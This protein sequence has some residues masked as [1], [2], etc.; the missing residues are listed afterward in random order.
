[1]FEFLRN[2]IVESA[3]IFNDVSFY[4]L[5]GLLLAGLIKV[6]LPVQFLTRHLS[7]KNYKSV[8]KAALIGVPLPLCSCSVLPTAV[9]LKKQGASNGATVAFLISTPETGVDSISVTY[10]LLDPL[11]TLLRPLAAF[12]T[13][14]TAGGAVNILE[15]R[16]DEKNGSE[17]T[18][19]K[20]NIEKKSEGRNSAKSS[21]RPPVRS[22][23]TAKGFKATLQYGFGDILPEIAGWFIMGILFAGIIS[24][25]L[26]DDFFT[27]YI[28][29][30]FLSM[31]L[32]II[33][34]IPLY[35]CATGSTPIAAAL[36][37]KGLNPG[38]ALIF[39]LVGPATNIGSFFV[40]R[41]YIKKKYL[42][43][44]LV[45]LIIVSLLF[46]FIVNL[47]YDGGG[48]P[49]RASQDGGRTGL[50]SWMQIFTSLILAYLLVKIFYQA[51]IHKRFLDFC[52]RLISR[53]G[54]RPG[55][56]VKTAFLLL[57]I[58]YL[59]S[60]FYSVRIGETAIVTSFG[61]VVRVAAEPGL[62]YRYPYPFS[63]IF[64]QNHEYIRQIEIGYRSSSE[65]SILAAV[66]ED[67]LSPVSAESS[68]S[69]DIPSV[70]TDVPE[71][72]LIFT[73]DENIIN[74]DCVV[75]YKISDP[76]KYYYKVNPKTDLV[77]S[78]I[79]SSIRR[80]F[81]RH[82]IMDLLVNER[83]AVSEE[84]LRESRALMEKFDIGI[85]LLRLNISNLHAPGNVHYYFRDVAS[86]LEDKEKVIH[87]AYK[88]ALD[89]VIR[90]RG[91]AVKIEK[92]ADSFKLNII[93]QSE[94]EATSF[95]ERYKAYSV[96]P[97]LTRFRM[98]IESI[99]ESLNG[100]NVIFMLKFKFPKAA[101]LWL[102]TNEKTVF[103]PYKEN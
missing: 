65:M 49:V 46:G 61:K 18:R 44:Y 57:V 31:I 26:P 6:L 3:N 56:F 54:I 21:S 2:I 35:I 23:F 81:N 72:G 82:N 89:T 29:N 70:G 96:D 1:L 24:A 8:L 28:D 68:T 66:G 76:Y 14:F 59:L 32:M 27:C 37:A 69:S 52:A 36:M 39:L 41:K 62:F 16:D 95:L 45:S 17:K 7:D 67:I 88:Y 73:G 100:A 93:S 74:L 60:G 34:G 15:R 103:L 19:G 97:M 79:M 101:E 43:A 91:E 11:F 5:F 55:V 78:L 58:F 48:S 50:P 9:A 75:H 30:T 99:E 98:Y 13:A 80:V 4:L 102:N 63:K 92:D 51:G 47:I 42:V 84:I 22:L 94:G 86:S 90:S 83:S 20:K 40:L 33:I 64:Y 12:L 71:E 87:S 53:F 25:V 38:A 77:R 10:A 85:D